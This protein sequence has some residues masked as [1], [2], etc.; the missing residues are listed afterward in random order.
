MRNS[1]S[2]QLYYNVITMIITLIFHPNKLDSF[3]FPDYSA[4]FKK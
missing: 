3:A 4:S 1:K 2:Y